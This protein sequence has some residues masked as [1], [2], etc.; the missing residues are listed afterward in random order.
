M[1][2][3]CFALLLVCMLPPVQ[4]LILGLDFSV[5]YSLNG[6]IGKSPLFDHVLR[7]FADE[8]GRERLLIALGVALLCMVF[9]SPNRRI[10][11]RRLALFLFVGTVIL[12]ALLAEAHVDN[13]ILRRSPSYY[14]QPF[15]SL[16]D[17]YGW[18]IQINDRR[19]FPSDEALALFI[20]AFMLLNLR[21]R[22]GSLLAFGGG[23]ALGLGRCIAGS[24][25]ASDVYLGALPMAWL[26]GTAATETRIS[27]LYVF[28]LEKVHALWDEAARNVRRGIVMIK[29]GRPFWS[30]RNV[31][32]MEVAVKRFVRLELPKLMQWPADVEPL[33]RMP[34][35]GLRSVVRFVEADGQKVVLRAYPLSARLEA[36]THARAQELLAHNGI[37][38]PRLL[39]V[40]DNPSRSG[41]IFL[42]EE[43]VE[44]I[45]VAPENL[46]V[47]QVLAVGEELGKLHRVT[48]TTWGRLDQPRSEEYYTVWLRRVQR[49]LSTIRR[50]GMPECNSSSAVRLLRWFRR[51]QPYLVDGRDF[52]LIHGKL[53][54]DN[55][56]FLPDGTYCLIDFTTL[57]YGV[58]ASDLVQVRRSICGGN[59]RLFDEFCTAYTRSL[60]PERSRENLR[61]LLPFQATDLVNQVLKIT[62]RLNR[63]RRRA[64]LESLEKRR[65]AWKEL[66]QL[67][68]ANRR[69]NPAEAPG[70]NREIA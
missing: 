11:A 66:M 42:V 12:V 22:R 31:Y 35:A 64:S 61:L 62:K 3:A 13:I 29:A 21:E 14:L 7:F 44:G 56:L 43:M 50:S 38:A 8:D 4:R 68:Q 55:G 46:T 27:G 69:E 2:A 67:T 16:N 34:L 57:E 41:A 23:A 63:S 58:A 39:H 28:Y 59:P 47:Q 40:V 30:T 70:S 17:I 5:A 9:L 49:A 6:M 65:A 20:A 1:L 36:E 51:W 45:T 53:H 60:G 37:R 19:S 32:H 24:T 52:S 25:W 26:L 18:D 15:I 48:A 54:T 10:A 33:V